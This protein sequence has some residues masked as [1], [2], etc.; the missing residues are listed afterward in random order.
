MLVSLLFLFVSFCFW[1]CLV[2]AGF[3]CYLDRC[4]L[5]F[6]EFSLML[7][8]VS[9]ICLVMLFFCGSVALGFC[10]HYFAGDRWGGASLFFMLSIFLSVMALLVCSYGLL[11]RLVMWEY[12]GVVRFF[13]ILFYG[14]CESL[15]ATLVTLFASR[16]GDVCFFGLIFFFYVYWGGS[17]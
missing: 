7:D 4:G 14:N 3:D 15:R 6:S 10:E 1:C 11:F 9:I 8:G 13:L 12:L 16:F 5:D 2:S 17:V